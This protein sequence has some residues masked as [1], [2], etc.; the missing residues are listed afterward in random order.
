MKQLVSSILVLLAFAST[1][2]NK[3]IGILEQ[4]ETIP[5]EDLIPRKDIELTRSQAEYVKSGGNEFALNLFK[6]ISKDESLVIS[7]LSVT[8]ALGMVD[9][10]ALANTKCE[11]ERVLGYDEESVDGLNNYCKTMISSAKEI[12]PTTKIEFAN[13]AIVNKTRAILRERF[14]NAIESNYL[15]DVCYKDFANEDVKGYINDWCENKTHGMIPGL[16]TNPPSP[17]EVAHF[18]NAVYFKGIWSSQFKKG[19]SRKEDFRDPYGKKHKVNMMR[20]EAHFNYA[21]VP[22]VCT[23]ICLPFGNQAFRMLFILPADGNL[24]ELK[25]TLSLEVWNDISTRLHDEKVDVRIPSFETTSE[26]PLKDYLHNL[27]IYDAFNPTASQFGLMCET[28]AWIDQIL[29][30]VKIIVDEQGSEAAAITDVKMAT[31]VMGPDG[32]PVIKFHADRPFLYV[33]TEV[34]TSSI[35]FLGQYTGIDI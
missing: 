15:A 19:D 23:A 33:V 13:A 18:L 8:F 10:G 25:K 1:S 7:P 35:I 17:R 21:E 30:K 16:L 22:G 34:S 6:E 4:D 5:L 26:L 3:E 9:N 31:T 29:H 2:C 14:K 28:D 27:G 20:Q 12:D 24:Y 11:I 32:I